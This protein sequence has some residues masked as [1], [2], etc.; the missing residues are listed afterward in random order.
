MLVFKKKEVLGS[1][2]MLVFKKK[3]FL[4]SS[5]PSSIQSYSH[6]CHN[7]LNVLPK[8]YQN[9]MFGIFYLAWSCIVFPF[10]CLTKRQLHK[11]IFVTIIPRW[12]HLIPAIQLIWKNNYGFL[13]SKNNLNFFSWIFT[14][15]RSIENHKFHVKA[16]LTKTKQKTLGVVHEYIFWA[17]SHLST[18]DFLVVFHGHKLGWK[19]N[20]VTFLRKYWSKTRRKTFKIKSKKK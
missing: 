9:D 12:R 11:T 3:E 5:F 19:N 13:A 1:S 14:I 10:K 2:W 8:I 18:S 4:G 15:Q 6:R 7:V 16:Q 17:K 20:I